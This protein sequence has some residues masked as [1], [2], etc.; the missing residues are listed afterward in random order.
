VAGFGKE[1]KDTAGKPTGKLLRPAGFGIVLRLGASGV[2]GEFV[3]GFDD[4]GARAGALADD[5]LDGNLF[6]GQQFA[7]T[8]DHETLVSLI[9][10]GGIVDEEDDGW[11]R[12]AGLGGVVDSRFAATGGA[13]EVFLEDLPHDAIEHAGGGTLVGFFE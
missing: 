12:F 6:I 5:E 8:I 10:E 11:R 4:A 2:F 1:E 3:E 7:E 9:D 13:G